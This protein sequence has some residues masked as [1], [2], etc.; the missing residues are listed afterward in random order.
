MG[1]YS[2][3]GE[4]MEQKELCQLWGSDGIVG[5]DEYSLLGE[6]IH[7]NH[8]C[9]SC[10][11]FDIVFDEGTDTWPGII[12]TDELECAV[13]SESVSR[14]LSSCASCAGFDIVFDEGTDTWPG[15]ITTDE[16]ECAVLS[17]VTSQRVVVFVPEYS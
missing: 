7:Y 17:E 6:T 3:L 5:G 15:I 10:A 11:G 1:W 13:L 2:V 9:A 4:H 14:S 12:T 16:L 8:S